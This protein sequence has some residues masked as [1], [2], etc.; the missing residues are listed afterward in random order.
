MKTKIETRLETHNQN[1][2]LHNQNR[3]IFFLTQ[4]ISIFRN[5]KSQN[6]RISAYSDISSSPTYQFTLKKTW[7]QQ[8]TT[9]ALEHQPICNRH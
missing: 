9:I 4:D 6:R 5:G 1:Q 2:S 3:S 7:Q 8:L